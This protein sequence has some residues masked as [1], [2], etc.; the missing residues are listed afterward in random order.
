MPPSLR[1][2]GIFQ[3]RHDN[4]PSPKPTRGKGDRGCLVR[5][6]LSRSLGSV[7]RDVSH[8]LAPTHHARGDTLHELVLSVCDRRRIHLV[9]QEALL[10]E[11][12]ELTRPTELVIK[13]VDLRVDTRLRE[14][15]LVVDEIVAE[16]IKR[17]CDLSVA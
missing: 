10:V 16:V 3:P 13:S 4:P 2:R 11:Q 8:V 1:L 9:S 17:A 14:L 6:S 7:S 12:V 5:R 15:A